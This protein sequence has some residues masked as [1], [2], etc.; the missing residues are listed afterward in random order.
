MFEIG[1]VCVKIA[2]RD[3]G[4]ICVVVDNIDD[5]TVLIEGATRRRKCNINHLEITDK[6]A[7][8]KK[9]A[10]NSEVVKALKEVDIEIAETKKKSKESK[11]RPRKVRV[12][13]KQTA[14]KPEQKAKTAKKETTKAESKK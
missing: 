14:E 5:K 12:N 6:I 4:K 8:V 3:A 11:P 7:K 9:G 2:G 10:S 13:N 1:T